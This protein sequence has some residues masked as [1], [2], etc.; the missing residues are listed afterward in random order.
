M[1][2]G[3]LRQAPPIVAIA[4][5]LLAFATP[6]RALSV[7]YECNTLPADDLAAPWLAAVSTC[8]YQVAA[9]G[10]LA[11]AD[12]SDQT[13]TASFARDESDLAAIP[14]LNIEARV[15]ALGNNNWG[16]EPTLLISHHDS[17]GATYLVYAVHLFPDHIELMRRNLD[18]GTETI[19]ATIS[20]PDLVSEFHVVRL[21]RTEASTRR[22]E[23]CLDGALVA[24]VAGEPTKWP[25][26]RIAFG[27]GYYVGAGISQWDYV[28]YWSGDATP[29]SRSG[30]G[31]LKARYR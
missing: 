18:V 22:F 26:S 27:H 16:S 10:Y 5:V 25:L 19:L 11:L 14:V 9:G 7:S 15:R 21:V 23:L 8:G 29:T 28:R 4:I 12:A 20:V 3:N 2:S 13:G 31:A 24:T 30:W 6:A 17:N 1:S